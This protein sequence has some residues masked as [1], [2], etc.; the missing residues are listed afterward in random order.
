MLNILKFQPPGWRG[1]CVIFALVLQLPSSPGTLGGRLLI[2]FI[3]A[4][5][6]LKILVKCHLPK[7]SNCSASSLAPFGQ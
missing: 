5:E 3:A 7:K 4:L 1:S 6:Y 2:S